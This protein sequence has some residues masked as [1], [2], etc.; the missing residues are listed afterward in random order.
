MNNPLEPILKYELNELEAKSYKL[1]L[2]WDAV[3]QKELPNY[4]TTRLKKTGDPRKCT[5]FKYCYKLATETN[6]L[7]EDKEYK[8]YITAQVQVLKS[9]TQDKMHALIEPHCL[10]GDKAWRRWEMWKNQFDKLKNEKSQK[11]VSIDSTPTNI[12]AYL[13]Q[14]KAFLIEK[15]G[16]LPTWEQ[17]ALAYKQLLVVNWGR[18]GKLS[19]Y[20]ILL[21]PFVKKATGGRLNTAFRVNFEVYR[22][23]I[24][25]EVEVYMQEMFPNEFIEDKT[26]RQT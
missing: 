11:L 23:S 16:D 19:P 9:I 3:I 21:S 24:T 18:I 15:F 13:T 10:V 7:I 25:N 12:R 6:G 4:H 22:S 8:L 20:Y 14:T 2:L 26:R 5:L 1:C 17:F